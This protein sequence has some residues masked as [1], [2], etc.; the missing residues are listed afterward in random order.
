MCSKCNDR[1]AAG[2]VTYNPNIERLELNLD[3]ISQ[4]VNKVFIVDNASENQNEIIELI[5]KYRN[6]EIFTNE[7]NFG[8]GR[9][10]NIIFLSAEDYYTYVLTLDQDSVCSYNMVEEL[11]KCFS[12]HIGIV[13][14]RIK[15]INRNDKFIVNRGIV[16]VSRCI[17]SGSLTKVKAWKNIGGYDEKMFIDGVDF[18]FCDRLI[19]N[20]YEIIENNNV[21]LKHEL[22]FTKIKR[23]LFWNAVVRN[24]SDFRKYYIAKNIVYLDRKNKCRT[25]P[26][27]TILREFKQIFIVF[28]YE[29]EK[30]KKIKRIILGMVDG[31]KEEI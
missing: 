23:F 14:P 7:K 28:L 29:Q 25:F 6:I 10:L 30:V 27:T 12:T 17:T 8:I 2:I 3:S 26:I 20:G 31:F 21:E 19:K 16:N 22:G 9:A 24:H 1:I 4:Q 15:D 11:Y 13:C 18:D 5:K